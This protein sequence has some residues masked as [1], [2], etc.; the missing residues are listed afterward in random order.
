VRNRQ[1]LYFYSD[2]PKKSGIENVQGRAEVLGMF[3][4]EANDGRSIITYVTV[5]YLIIPPHLGESH[6]HMTVCDHIMEHWKLRDE[7]IKYSRR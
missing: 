2:T 6:R 3:E 1:R 4:V 5:P 7:G